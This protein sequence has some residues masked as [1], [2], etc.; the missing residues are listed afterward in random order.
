MKHLIINFISYL[1]LVTLVSCEENIVR[2]KFFD[3]DTV[4]QVSLDSFGKNNYEGSIPYLD[5]KAIDYTLPD[6]YQHKP[7]LLRNGITVMSWDKAG[8]KDAK[9]F[10]QFFE[11]FQFAVQDRNKEKIATYIKFPLPNIATKK[12]FL[13]N[14]DAIF[15]KE[16]T[17]EIM[18]QNPNEIYRDKHGAMI[19]K[20]GQLWF[21][22]V[23]SSYKIVAINWN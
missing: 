13:E 18:H 5:S 17:D 11:Q 12:E 15:N 7:Q 19:G 20:D 6:E 23:G 21:K 2:V 16:F 8:F 10:I 3:Q 22:P 1:A 4:K 14:F 9:Q